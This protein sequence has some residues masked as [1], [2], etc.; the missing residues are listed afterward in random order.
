MPFF[1]LVFKTKQKQMTNIR[2]SLKRIVFSL[3]FIFSAL[4]T[5]LAQYGAL[6]QYRMEVGVMAGASFYIGDANPTKLFNRAEPSVGG[7]IR[8]NLN[9]RWVL[10]GSAMYGKVAG[11]TRDYPN[12]F[13]MNQYAYFERKFIDIGAN[14]EFNFIDYGLPSYV[15]GSKWYS[16][17][18]FLGVGMT[19]FKDDSDNSRMEFNFPF[20]V[21]F[22]VKIIRK[23]NIGVEWS[24]HTLFIDDFDVKNEKSKFLDN[25]Y[26][27][28]GISKIKNNDKYS[29]AK[30]FFTFDLF[31]RQ[32]CKN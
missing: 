11:D 20:G 31:K 29:I 9:P 21:G 8:Y 1:P 15:H 30:V 18:I 25:P 14:L 32:H 2:L 13:P 24:M 23:F 27:V 16:P 5:T 3:I 19:T 28:K 10:K 6:D 12:K 17:Y 26:G 22:K 7:V 4:T